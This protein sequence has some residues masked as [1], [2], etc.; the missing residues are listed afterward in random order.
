MNN[1]IEEKAAKIAIKLW[2]T[3][4]LG[5]AKFSKEVE[6]SLNEVVEVRE[7]EILEEIEKSKKEEGQTEEC[8]D[9]LAMN[10]LIGKNKGWNECL[11]NIKS[12]ISRKI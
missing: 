12:I 7:K 6:T 9:V 5:Y 11:E 1:L 2:K 8:K 3:Y 4:Q 10:Y